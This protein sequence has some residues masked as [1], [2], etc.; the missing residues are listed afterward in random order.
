MSCGHW[1]AGAVGSPGLEHS[2]LSDARPFG[3]GCSAARA[4]QA[5]GARAVP[6]SPVPS[7]STRVEPGTELA[8]GK[9]TRYRPFFRGNK[10]G[11]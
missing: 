4:L 9:R 11:L 3:S 5:G 8:R 1:P 10:T 7:V 2:C 6:Q